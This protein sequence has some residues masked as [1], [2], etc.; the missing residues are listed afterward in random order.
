MAGD[1]ASNDRATA[2]GLGVGL[3]ALALATLS[4]AGVYMSKYSSLKK[5]RDLARARGIP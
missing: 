1:D 4:A 5:E 3:G 2:I